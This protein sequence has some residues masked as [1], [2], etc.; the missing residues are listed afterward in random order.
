MKELIIIGVVAFV[1]INVAADDYA[2]ESAEYDKY[3]EMVEIYM[4]TSGREGWP[5]YEGECK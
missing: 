4:A 3:C 5:P 1:I 2:D